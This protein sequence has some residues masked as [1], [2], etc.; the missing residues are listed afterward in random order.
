MPILDILKRN[1]RLCEASEDFVMLGR[2]EVFI[3]DDK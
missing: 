1:P 3:V 2:D